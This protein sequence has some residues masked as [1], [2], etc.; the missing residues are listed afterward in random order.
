M[1]MPSEIDEYMSGFASITAL[2]GWRIAGSAMLVR[3][4]PRRY[5]CPRATCPGSA[6]LKLSGRSQQSA[7]RIRRGRCVV[8]QVKLGSKGGRT[9][10]QT[11]A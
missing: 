5:S 1:K 11:P 7:P 9:S 4:R 8:H 10:R 2:T 3:W 6:W